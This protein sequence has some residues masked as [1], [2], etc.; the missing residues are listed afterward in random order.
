MPRTQQDSAERIVGKFS[1]WSRRRHAYHQVHAQSLDQLPRVR[2]D[3]L[4]P[5]SD[6]WTAQLVTQLLLEVCPR[7]VTADEEFVVSA[8]DALAAY[9]RYFDDTGA[10][11][12]DALPRLLS[13]VA[14]AATESPAAMADT[15]PF[16]LAK[17]MLAQMLA[18][19]VQSED[20]GAMQQWIEDFN[21]RPLVERKALTDPLLGLPSASAGPRRPA[22]R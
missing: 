13:T 9:L 4:G 3:Y 20:P 8:A 6:W 12:G 19:G 14:G 2:R 18:D 16:G 17:G 15:S 1:A 22:R 11:S 10:L 5:D 7:K 21:N